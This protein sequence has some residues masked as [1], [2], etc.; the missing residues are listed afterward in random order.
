MTDHDGVFEPLRGK[1]RR[2]RQALLETAER[3]GKSPV[4]DPAMR[5]ALGEAVQHLL[6]RGQI[7][8]EVSAAADAEALGRAFVTALVQGKGRAAV[9]L[10][11]GPEPGGVAK[12]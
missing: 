5:E 12:G 4:G 10:V 9:D 1:R 7:G 6:R 3:W 8:G 2:V 11:L